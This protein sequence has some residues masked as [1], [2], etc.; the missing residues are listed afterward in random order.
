MNQAAASNAA[1]QNQIDSSVKAINNAYS[2][3]ARQLQYQTYGKSLQDYYNTQ[4]NNQEA[5]NARNMTFAN[6]RSGITGG[7]QAS[8]NNAQ[9][10]KDYTNALLQA[11]QQA[12]SGVSALQNSDVAAKN[13]LIG[14]ATA[15]D[16]TA[17]I[18]ANI[19][20]AQGASLGAAGAYGQ[21]N[22]LGNLFAATEQINQAEAQA[23]ANRRAQ[24]AVR[25]HIRWHFWR[26][27]NTVFSYG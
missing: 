20:A 10:Q 22:A 25:Q 13:Q 7:S 18:P 16:Y 17:A 27:I 26:R 15:G 6:A 23:A 1:T 12:Q 19:A 14:E 5:I 21:A 8:D 2:S 11:S 24:I 4:V 9:L 3:P